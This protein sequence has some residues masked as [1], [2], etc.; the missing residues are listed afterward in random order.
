LALIEEKKN[1]RPDEA[2]VNDFA[3][4]IALGCPADETGPG[5]LGLILI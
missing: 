5:F 3:R 1:K 2:T 4:A